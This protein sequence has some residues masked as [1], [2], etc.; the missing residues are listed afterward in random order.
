MKLLITGAF[1]FCLISSGVKFAS[2]DAPQR[3]PVRQ[4]HTE[5]NKTIP[6]PTNRGG[7]EGEDI[8]PG[9]PSPAAALIFG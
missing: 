5:K 9:S 3:E 1:L 7:A 6:E 2:Y 4:L 8:F